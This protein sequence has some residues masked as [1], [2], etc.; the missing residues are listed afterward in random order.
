[1]EL[2]ISVGPVQPVKVDHLQRWSQTFQS[3]GTETD[4]S[5]WLPTKIFGIMESTP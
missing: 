3:G 2:Q 4:L 1:M 5:I